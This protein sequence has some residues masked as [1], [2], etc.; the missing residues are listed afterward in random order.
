MS[1]EPPAYPLVA[2]PR[3]LDRL[4]HLRT[5]AG[6]V[7]C[8]PSLRARASCRRVSELRCC[9]EDGSIAS[10]LRR[11]N[12]LRVVVRCGWMVQAAARRGRRRGRRSKP[13]P[14][15]P[16]GH[17]VRYGKDARDH[18]QAWGLIHR[19]APHSLPAGPWVAQEFDTV[20]SWRVACTGSTVQVFLCETAARAC[21]PHPPL[22]CRS[23]RSHRRAH[24]H[25]MRG[26]V[27][28]PQLQRSKHW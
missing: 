14:P 13:R 23:P 7:T 18:R 28:G 24:G 4:P 3:D 25:G 22:R 11:I 8:R 21:P 26:R 16:P 12:R 2:M 1:S 17:R 27:Q 5:S 19:R 10:L 15:R 20:T 9:G 6:P